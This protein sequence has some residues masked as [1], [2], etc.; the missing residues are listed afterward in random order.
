MRKLI[1]ATAIIL[2][3]TSAFAGPR[4]LSSAEPVEPQKRIHQAEVTILPAPAEQ[5]AAATVEPP[6]RVE[7]PPLTVE[8]KLKASG[9]IKPD[10]AAQPVEARPVEAKPVEVQAPVQAQPIAKPVQA[11]APVQAQPEQKPV[12]RVAKRRESDEHK[13]RR[14]AARFGISW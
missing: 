2:L 3:S 5:P 9:E 14:I 12:K 11:Q 4:G 8:E 6:L 7:P 10:A 1:L 13:A